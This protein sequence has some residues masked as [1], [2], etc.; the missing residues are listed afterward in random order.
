MQV[1]RGSV[2]QG[3][4]RGGRRSD[5][6]FRWGARRAATVPLLPALL[7]F[8]AALALALPG[9][10]P[11]V[12]GPRI[13]GGAG[14]PIND[15]PFQVALYNPHAGSIAAGFFCGGVIIDA[16]HVA[17]AA[18]CAIDEA[19]GEVTPPG[20]IAVLAGSSSL[21]SPV[22][23]PAGAIEDPVAATSID[24]HY[25]PAIND[26]DVAVITLARPLWSGPAPP[27]DGA[28]TIAPIAV[29]ASLA[30]AYATPAAVAAPILAT[31]SGWGDTRAE[32]PASQGLAGSYPMGLQATQLPL[33]SSEACGTSYAN[34]LNSQP[35]TP[36]MVCAGYQAG[37]HDSC[38]GDSGGPLLV[39]RDS[40]A[41]P[42]ADYV[43]VGLVSF[44]E[45]CAQA[46]SP[47]VYASIA[48]PPIAAFLT[49]DP[50]QTP[51]GQSALAHPRYVHACTRARRPCQSLASAPAGHH[52]HHHRQ[53]HH[54]AHRH[55]H[56]HSHR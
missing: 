54:H 38:F 33:I 1:R 3:Q 29:S 36:R 52:H 30:A 41:A 25:D 49:S 24:P 45:G 56:R 47:G 8:L 43:L 6:R 27:I 19:S 40:P 14:V 21:G 51:L 9:S 32:S 4:G 7:P 35:I 13:V 17:T 42:P 48:A 23:A 11:G 53:Q 34:P 12:V 5:R 50:P 20:D 28:S 2:V 15:F 26:Y 46:E 55:H 31:V 39:D 37:G 16:T 18:H 44:G 22:Q 10:A